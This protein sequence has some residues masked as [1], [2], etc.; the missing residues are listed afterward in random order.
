MSTQEKLQNRLADVFV[1]FLTA[2][3][4]SRAAN[5]VVN[6]LL[7]TTLPNTIDKDRNEF[8]RILS[9]QVET[10]LG[11]SASLMFRTEGHLHDCLQN[12]LDEYLNAMDG[13]LYTDPIVI[14]ER[15]YDH[16]DD[17][18]MNEDEDEMRYD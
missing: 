1:A 8:V 12:L 7:G 6:H 18:D 14:H 5:S 2:T 15:V 17:E 3:H 10:E 9:E 4:N 11:V 13:V 16:D